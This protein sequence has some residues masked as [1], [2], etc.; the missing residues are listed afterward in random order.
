VEHHATAAAVS[1]P[2][3]AYSIFQI[4]DLV[5]LNGL[6]TRIGN[7]QGFAGNGITHLELVFGVRAFPPPKRNSRTSLRMLPRTL[8]A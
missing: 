7:R 5:E 4:A 2:H 6:Q 8:S 1:L 3:L